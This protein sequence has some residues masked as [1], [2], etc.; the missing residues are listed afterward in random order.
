[1]VGPVPP[2]LD[3]SRGFR[4]SAERAGLSWGVP[5]GRE[6][7]SIYDLRLSIEDSQAVRV[8]ATFGSKMGK[9]CAE[10][11]FGKWLV[12]RQKLRER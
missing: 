7:L 1:M 12:N 3:R 10:S 4:P 8:P 11:R 9:L 6:G 2:G 5:T